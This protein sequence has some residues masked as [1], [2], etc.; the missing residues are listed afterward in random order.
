MVPHWWFV[1]HSWLSLRISQ[2]ISLLWLQSL[3]QVV[4]VYARCMAK[5]FFCLQTSLYLRGPSL[6][7]FQNRSFKV[8]LKVFVIF[9]N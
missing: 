9:L 1:I 5:T 3:P 6:L 8:W 4:R 2:L 7:I